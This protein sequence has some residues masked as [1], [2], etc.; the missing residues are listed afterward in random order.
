MLLLT[1]DYMFRQKSRFDNEF[2]VLLRDA[3]STS[4]TVDRRFISSLNVD[5]KRIS[6]YGDF[7]GD[8][9]VLVVNWMCLGR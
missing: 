6:R 2:E 7:G 5:K 4:P 3:G 9:V 8:E 1:Y